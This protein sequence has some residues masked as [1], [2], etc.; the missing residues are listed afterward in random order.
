MPRS[1]R[2]FA[3]QFQV[4]VFETRADDLEPIRFSGG[5]QTC[6][7]LARPLGALLVHRAITRPAHQG[8]A[9]GGA[10]DRVDRPDLYQAAVGDDARAIAELR[11]L[12][13]VMRGQEDGRSLLLELLDQ[14]PEL[15]ARLGVEPRR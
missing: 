10:P 1:L 3:H 9:R 13:E 8:D 12:V 14:G 7:E 5:G 11:G 4:D 2:S 15:A 6:D